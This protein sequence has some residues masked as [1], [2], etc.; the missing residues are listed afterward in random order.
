MDSGAGER[1]LPIKAIA[2]DSDVIPSTHIAAPDL[3]TVTVSEDLMPSFHLPGM[4]NEHIY[5]CRQ[6]THTHKIK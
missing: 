5:T 6:N 3:P 2:N 1:A 4:R